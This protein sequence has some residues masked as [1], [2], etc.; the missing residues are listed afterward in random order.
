[1]PEI[2]RLIILIPLLLAAPWASAQAP[3]KT[4]SA[5]VE[6]LHAELL[7]VMKN[8]DELGYAGRYRQLEPVIKRSFD[9]P[10]LARS[11]VRGYWDKF[12]PAQQEQFIADFRRLSIATYAQRFDGYDGE[13][14]KTLETSEIARGNL[15]VKTRLIK[16]DGESVSLDYILAPQDGAWRIVNVVAQGVSDL[17]LKR[18]QYV[19]VLKK[20]GV[21]TFLARIQAQVQELPALKATE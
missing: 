14:F 10:A 2:A 4:P 19:G 8:A 11:S 13:I 18:S 12:T 6:A 21:E 9:L 20:Q 1:M 16:R 5:V 17:A 3:E 7:Q 15:R